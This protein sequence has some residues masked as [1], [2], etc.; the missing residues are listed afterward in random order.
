MYHALA[1]MKISSAKQLLNNFESNSL[2]P[3]ILMALFFMILY[4]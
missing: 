4:F 1:L 3:S 2:K